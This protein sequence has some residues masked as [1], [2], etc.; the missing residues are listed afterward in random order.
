MKTKRILLLTMFMLLTLGTTAV[1]A[2]PPE[3]GYPWREHAMP[4]DYEFVN[5][6]DNH[7]QTRQLQNDTLVGFIY[8]RFTGEEID[9][10]PVAV[11]A[12]CD[13]PTLDCRVGW[14]V[15]GVRMQAT[16]VQKGP[17]K[18]KVNAASLPVEPGYTHFHWEGSP[19]KPCGLVLDD[20]ETDPVWYD[21]YLLKRTA[22]E[23]F[24]WFGGSGNEEHN[25]RLVIP[26]VDPHSNIV[27]SWDY[28]GGGGGHGGGCGGHDDGGS[29]DGGCGGCS[30][31]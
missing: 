24:Y 2:G 30:G 22:V 17:R 7:Q 20:G 5:L 31:H 25:G 10:I 19:P 3:T 18:W 6:I 16:L 23:Q 21:G 15:D 13:D 1:M 9:G 26:G 28:S 14:V 12:D 8:I 27:T 11:R 4:F 29:D